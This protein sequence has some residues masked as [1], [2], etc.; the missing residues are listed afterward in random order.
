[1]CLRHGLVADFVPQLVVGSLFL[2]AVL[3]TCRP[4][5]SYFHQREWNVSLL[6]MVTS[7]DP[8]ARD[9]ACSLRS[10]NAATDFASKQVRYAIKTSNSP[11][12]ACSHL[13][14]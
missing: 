12:P 5:V 13:N 3:R 2:V 8:E 10:P 6:Q 7:L 9:A 1:M 14:C 11:S 4:I